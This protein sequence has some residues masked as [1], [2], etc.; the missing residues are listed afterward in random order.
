MTTVKQERFDS[1][2]LFKSEIKRGL[3]LLLDPEKMRGS[4]ARCNTEEES[5]IRGYHYFACI[6]TGFT[7][8]LSFWIPMSSRYKPNRTYVGQTSKRGCKIL[9]WR[10][11]LHVEEPDLDGN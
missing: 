5:Q 1:Y 3:V 10:N 7:N 2:D 9:G 11:N 4:G 6:G 8:D